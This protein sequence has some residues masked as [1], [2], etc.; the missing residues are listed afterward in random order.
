MAR[1]EYAYHFTGLRLM[2]NWARP[3]V[4]VFTV[5]V[6]SMI[7]CV[8]PFDPASVPAQPSDI[9]VRGDNA[10]IPMLTSD[11]CFHNV[12]ILCGAQSLYYGLYGCYADDIDELYSLIGD[13]L[14]CP[15]KVELYE[16]TCCSPD[17]FWLQCQ[18]YPLHAGGGPGTYWNPYQR[19][20]THCRSHMMAIASSEAMFY[21][22]FVRYGTMDELLQAGYGPYLT[23][24]GCHLDYVIDLGPETYTLI[25]PMPTSPNHGS[26]VDGMIS[27]Q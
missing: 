5:S 24:P 27:W 13:T 1:V 7:G 9:G 18:E 16:I 10:S 26:V 22:Q 21:G 20:V 25:C 2:M 8:D 4:I 11:S 19:A 17:S 12:A 23:C 3:A 14:R 6:F 15:W